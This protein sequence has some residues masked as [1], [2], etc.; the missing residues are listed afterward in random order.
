VKNDCYADLGEIKLNAEEIVSVMTEQGLRITEQRR[1]LAELF[2]G[3]EGYLSPKEVY[4][5]LGK[6]Y[7]GLSFDTVYRNLRLMNDMNILEQLVFEE[8]IKFKLRCG[9]SNHHHHL[10]CLECE[11]TYPIVF[12]PMDGVSNIPDQFEVVKHK[13]EV[14]GY[15]KECRTEG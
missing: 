9:E 7:S 4:E 15:C 2:A 3:K 11:K 14:Y 1:T 5:H 6:Y 10:I 8:G 13:F 12:C